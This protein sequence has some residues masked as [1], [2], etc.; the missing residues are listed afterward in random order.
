MTLPNLPEPA[1]LVLQDT[2]MPIDA[3]WCLNGSLFWLI[4]GMSESDGLYVGHC[5]GMDTQR[6]TCQPDFESR[7]WL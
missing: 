6:S 2:R 5:D 1:K 7:K 3:F 4:R